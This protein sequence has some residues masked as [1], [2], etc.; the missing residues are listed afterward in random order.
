[1]QQKERFYNGREQLKI[2]EGSGI[3]EGKIRHMINSK[4]EATR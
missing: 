2:R 4:E 1:V 3:Y